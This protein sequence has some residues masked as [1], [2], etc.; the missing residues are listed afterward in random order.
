MCISKYVYGVIKRIENNNKFRNRNKLLLYVLKN[1][2]KIYKE[3]KE[4][5]EINNQF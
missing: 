4:K 2:L 5:T 1:V 3:D